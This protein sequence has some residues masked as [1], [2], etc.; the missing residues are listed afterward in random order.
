[1]DHGRAQHPVRHRTGRRT[2]VGLNAARCLLC[3]SQHRIGDEAREHAT[4]VI[5]QYLVRL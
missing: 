4:Q 3:C 2:G 1:M 5:G